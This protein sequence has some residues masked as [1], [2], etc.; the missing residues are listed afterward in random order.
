VAQVAVV[1]ESSEPELLHPELPT[2]VEVE[3]AQAELALVQAEAYKAA[4]VARESSL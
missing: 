2:V 1:L 4:T 3:A